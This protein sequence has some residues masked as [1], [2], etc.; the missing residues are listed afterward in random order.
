VRIAKATSVIHT[1]FALQEGKQ[2]RGEPVAELVQSILQLGTIDTAG[3]IAVEVVEDALP[4]LARYRQM[5]LGVGCE[6]RVH[7]FMYFHRP[8]N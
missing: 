4:I 8:V 3:S 6:E 7:T 1:V 2:L 5:P